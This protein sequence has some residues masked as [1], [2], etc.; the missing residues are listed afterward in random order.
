MTSESEE[1][2]QSRYVLTHGDL[3]AIVYEVFYTLFSTLFKDHNPS[4]VR[5]TV[6][7]HSV[8]RGHKAHNETI[9]IV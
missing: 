7:Q 6:I 8:T 4:F 1:V 5:P 3:N 2:F 9:G